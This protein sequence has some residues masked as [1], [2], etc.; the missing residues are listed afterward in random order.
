LLV[1]ADLSPGALSA[2]IRRAQ[3]DKVSYTLVVGEGVAARVVS[4]RTR[5]GQR[6]PATP[7]NEMAKQL[8]AEVVP[9]VVG[10]TSQSGAS[11]S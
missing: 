8:V 9:P 5:V 1:D 3:L 7:F 6:S 11:P 2:R 10:G 4:P